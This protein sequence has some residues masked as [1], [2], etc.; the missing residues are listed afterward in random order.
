MTKQRQKAPRYGPFPHDAFGGH[1]IVDVRETA[2]R[3]LG[4]KWPGKSHEDLEDA[5]SEG[6][7]DL[8]E[9]WPF[10]PS[11]VR[12]LAEGDPEK[13]FQFAVRYTYGQCLTGFEQDRDRNIRNP[14]DAIVDTA[15][16]A[17][18]YVGTVWAERMRQV[19]EEFSDEERE[20]LMLARL[21]AKHGTEGLRERADALS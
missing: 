11:T 4:K 16:N 5:V 8:I 7:L 10:M 1:T 3:L 17:A 21:L 9:L 19:D 12:V 20:D 6:M 2:F 13:V 14:V 15:E 18:E